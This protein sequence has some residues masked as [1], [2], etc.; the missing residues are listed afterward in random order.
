MKATK[1]LKKRKRHYQCVK[2]IVYSNEC[3]LCYPSAIYEL[4]SYLLSHFVSLSV[5]T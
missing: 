2:T 5:S 4:I 1:M 3:T